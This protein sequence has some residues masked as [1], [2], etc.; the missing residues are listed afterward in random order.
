[1]IKYLITKKVRN[2]AMKKTKKA[3]I[4]S[5]IV[6]TGIGAICS[7]NAM[8]KMKQNNEQED[9]ENDEYEQKLIPEVCGCEHHHEHYHNHVDK[10][11]GCE[12]GHNHHHNGE[13]KKEGCECHSHKE[14][15]V[16]GFKEIQPEKTE[17]EEKIEEFNS[18]RITDENT[19]DA[20]TDEMLSKLNKVEDTKDEVIINQ[21]DYQKEKYEEYEYYEDAL[22]KE[23][24]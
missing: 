5:G 14:N 2:E 10:K 1:M 20:S 11:S 19:P 3:L 7:Y 6:L 23:E 12:C 17:L 16:T 8:K 13:S 21:A 22:K 15:I 4:Y 9:I 18:K 24:Q